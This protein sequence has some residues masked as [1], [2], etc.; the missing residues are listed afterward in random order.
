M[1]LGILVSPPSLEVDRDWACFLALELL[2][3]KLMEGFLLE[4]NIM[5][6]CLN[7]FAIASV[8]SVCLV[9]TLDLYLVYALG[10]V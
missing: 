1:K 9:A 4:G 6:G 10:V 7:F 8:S 3:P 2:L 5:L